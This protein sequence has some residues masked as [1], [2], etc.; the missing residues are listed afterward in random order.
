VE[1]QLVW[2]DNQP[3][4]ELAG[5]MVMFESEEHQTV[6]RSVVQSDATFRLTTENPDDGVPP[7][8][9]RVYIVESRAGSVGEGPVAPPKMDGRYARPESSGLEVTVPPEITPVVFKV[10]R[11]KR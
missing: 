5:S 9:H 7:G 3:A 2:S 11:A 6:S 8:R 4:T 10:E 1:G